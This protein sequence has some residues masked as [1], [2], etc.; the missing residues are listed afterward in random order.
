M[1]SNETDMN[2]YGCINVS[3]NKTQLQQLQLGHQQYINNNSNNG[4]HQHNQRAGN[5][6]ISVMQWQI[7]N[8]G[9]NINNTP[10]NE[11]QQQNQHAR[12]DNIYTQRQGQQ[13][14]HDQND[15]QHECNAASQG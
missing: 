6:N 12:N 8:N 1:Y 2:L 3:R 11:Q 9:D 5:M 15:T 4:E 14:T 7:E 10:S 13:S